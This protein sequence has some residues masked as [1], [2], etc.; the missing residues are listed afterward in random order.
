MSSD[1]ARGTDRK[2]P[3]PAP[4][5]EAAIRGLER[6]V[7]TQVQILAAKLRVDLDRDLKR[8]T[9]DDIKRIANSAA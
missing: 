8:S 7:Y 6:E 5:G 2:K 9:P 4:A 3:A 1:T